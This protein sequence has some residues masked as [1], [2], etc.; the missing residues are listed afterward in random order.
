M[1][2]FFFKGSRL[3]KILIPIFFLLCMILLSSFALAEDKKEEEKEGIL[4]FNDKLKKIEIDT[5]KSAKMENFSFKKDI[6]E[7][8]LESGYI[9]LTKPMPEFPNAGGAYFIGQGRMIFTP[10]NKVEKE[11][12]KKYTEKEKLNESFTE[13]FIRFNDNT[14]QIFEPLMKTANEEEAKKAAEHFKNKQGLLV[15]L[16]VNPEALILSDYLNKISL[17]QYLLV[18]TDLEKIGQIVFFYSPAGFGFLGSAEEV[19]LFKLERLGFGKS[20]FENIISLFNRKEDYEQGIDLDYEEKDAL[21]INHY[22]MDFTIE[23]GSLLMMAKVGIRFEP[24]LDN[25]AAITLDFIDDPERHDKMITDLKITD[26]QGKDLPYIYK[27]GSILIQLP[28][29]LNKGEAGIVNVHYKADFIRP[30]PVV[31]LPPGYKLDSSLEFLPEGESTFTLLNTYSWFPQYGYLKRST[32]DMTMRV[33]KPHIAVASGTT[34]KRWEEGPYNCLHSKENIPVLLTSV[35][36]GKYITIKDDS[37]RPV[38]YVHSLFKQQGQ[39]EPILKEARTV[40]DEYE[41]YFGPFPYDEFDIAQMGF[42]YGF[43]QA[44]PGLV[45]LTGEAFLGPNE[46][47][48]IPWVSAYRV[49]DLRS[50]FLSHEI[51]HEWWAHVVAW[52][53]YHEQWLSESFTEYMAGLYLLASKGEKEFEYKLKSWKEYAYDQKDAGPIWLGGRLQKGYIASLYFKGPYV[54]HMLRK[55]F[56]F[57]YGAEEGDKLFFQCMRNFC[58]RFRDQNP[59]TKDFQRIVKEVTKIDMDW[60]FNQWFREAG[61]PELRVSYN[62]RQTEDGKYLVEV[63]VRQTDKEH[64]KAMLVPVFFHFG[65]DKIHRKDMYTDKEEGILKMKFPEKPETVTVDDTKELLAT[66]VYE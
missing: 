44:P 7:W 60:F 52:K 25:T 19:G 65:V 43:G 24:F 38:I 21:H 3:S 40:V 11:E 37:K 41:K 64:I 20:S 2:R 47:E 17:N 57:K 50:G 45:Q 22:D 56:T 59:T 62:S 27:N 51:G 29:V 49:A 8:K 35:L 9:Y 14:R 32:F 5:S 66:I 48:A 58:D 42:F 26:D 55:A 53:N 54:L 10:P 36:F 4:G 12:L 1:Y 30:D 33:P 6:V 23:P 46:L 28:K 18:L 16:L 34:L 39:A 63:K 61:F 15:G 13:A 31:S